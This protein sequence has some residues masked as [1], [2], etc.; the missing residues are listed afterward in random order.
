MMAWRFGGTGGN[1]LNYISALTALQA[2]HGD[3]LGWA[4][5]NDLYP[6]QDPGAEVTIPSTGCQFDS[7]K[8]KSMMKLPGNFEMLFN[9]YQQTQMGQTQLLESLGI[10]T[11][12]GSN[13][14]VVHPKKND[15]EKC[16]GSRRTSNG[17]FYSPDC[18]G[19]RVTWCWYRRCGDDDAPST[20]NINWCE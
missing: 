9:Q 11:K 17:S 3:A 5:F 7:C 12:F 4:M 14:W 19:D 18:L 13:A 10:P 1:E 16:Y 8:P 15:Y 6:Q 20:F 2:E